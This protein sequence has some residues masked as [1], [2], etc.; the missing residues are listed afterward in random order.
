MKDILLIGATG[1]LGG[2]LLAGA[3]ADRIHAPNREV[4]DITD[5]ESVLRCI[6]IYQ[7][8]III[9]TAAFHNVPQCEEQ[10]DQAMKVNC[11]AVYRLAR[12]CAE[13]NIRLVTFSTDYVFDGGQ[14]TPYVETDMPAPLQIYGISR[15][16]G[17]HAALAA[18]PRHAYVVRTCGL[19]GE[20]GAVSKGGNFV[21]KRVADA[22]QTDKLDM[23]SDQTVIPTYTADLAEAVIALINCEGA[24]PG[25]YHLVNQGE[26]TWAEFTAA[27]YEACGL[28]TVVNPVDR[29]GLSGGMRRPSYSVIANT[30]AAALGIELPH[31]RDALK[32]YLSRKGFRTT[33]D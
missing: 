16:A 4:L 24:E 19:Y 7:P 17:E 31:W 11:V 33:T 21:D 3:A 25:V 30:R 5:A 6:D 28:A 22:R 23:S 8:R 20:Q 29:G 27:I 26:C 15:L 9:N 1:Q 2:S 12:L 13:R 18:A 10:A 14:R 32:R